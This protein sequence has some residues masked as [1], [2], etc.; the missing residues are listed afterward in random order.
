M[1]TAQ[2]G[3]I[4]HQPLV[5]DKVTLHFNFEFNSSDLDDASTSYLD[6]LVAALDENRHLKIQ[7]TG[8]TDNVGSAKFNEKL[9]LYR[10]NS[11]KE[12]L[13]SKGISSERI[14]AAGKGLTEPVDDNR[15]EKGRA[16][17]RRVELVILYAE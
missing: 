10:A 12:Y 15:T 8:H 1:A 7:L 6:D 9:S 11:I 2:A 4:T 16:K 14:N 17:N 5:L 3:K 13:V